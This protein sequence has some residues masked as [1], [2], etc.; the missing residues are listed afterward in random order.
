MKRLIVSF[1]IFSSLVIAGQ[2][3]VPEGKIFF[4][5]HSP[6]GVQVHTHLNGKDLKAIGVK[7]GRMQFDWSG[8]EFKER[9]KY[10]FT[11]YDK[12]VADYL[13]NGINILGILAYHEGNPLYPQPKDDFDSV[14]KG[15]AGF[16]QACARHY[17]GKVK[18]WELGNEPE[19]CSV[20]GFYAKPENYTLIA[21]AAAKAI[22]EVDTEVKVG[23]LSVAWMD[24]GFISKSFELGLLKDRTI[25][26]V[27]F[28]GYHRANLLPESGLK[29]DVSWLRNLIRQYA[30]AGQKI[31]VVDSE[32]GYC[33]MDFLA[34]KPWD[35]WRNM[36]YTESEQAAYLARHFL[37][38]MALGIE[39]IVWYKD[40]N[41]EHGYS[42]Y[43]GLSDSRLRPMGVVYRNLSS[44]FDTNPKQMINRQYPV[45]LV[46][47]PDQTCDPNSF[48]KVKSYLRTYLKKQTLIIALWNPV[49]AFD[50]KILQSRQRIGGDYYEAWRA[51]SPEDKVEIPVQIRIGNLLKDE[52]KK[53]FVYNLLATEEKK[54][55]TPVKM[56][57]SGNAGTTE[58][59][60]VGPM[61]AVIVIELK[62]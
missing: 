41:G 15:Y 28:H 21:R 1:F 31:M 25:D 9:G 11:V 20:G 55:Q 33:L 38:E 49:E 40:M 4:P 32:R 46:D 8:A 35:G 19:T 44:L 23:A 57:F 36:V 60:K 56:N 45:T 48:M 54:L 37:E 53:V 29:E 39:V 12:V 34:P 59:I 27:T 47:L 26:A 16:S 51:V 24:R 42:L 7:W 22:R 58:T 61:P 52:I 62:K 6:F 50:G 30:P 3:R 13:S 2:D 18:F 17:K 10:D 43:E 5:D 14:V